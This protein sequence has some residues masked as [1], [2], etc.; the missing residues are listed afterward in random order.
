MTEPDNPEAQT[1]AAALNAELVQT[2]VVLTADQLCSL[3][4][5]RARLEQSFD[6]LG[7][8]FFTIDGVLNGSKITGAMFA[9]ECILVFAISER[10]AQ[11]QANA[12]L[13]QTVELLQEE[14]RYRDVLGTGATGSGLESPNVGGRR[15]RASEEGRELSGNP[16]L[17]DIIASEI[18]GLPW[19]G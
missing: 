12:G 9:G 17:R 13:R 18:G 7:A 10:A 19:K 3:I 14:Y 1:K 2:R 5:P 16:R 6:Q 8:H 4:A 15:A 11:E